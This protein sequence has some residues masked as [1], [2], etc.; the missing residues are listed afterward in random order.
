M[1][2]E[3]IESRLQRIEDERA[4]EKLVNTYA[5]RADAFDWAGWSETFTEDAIFD[6]AGMF[7][8]MKGRQ[9][10]H[11]LFKGDMDDLYENMQHVIVNL[12]F[13][14]AGDCASGTGNLIFA[15]TMDKDQLTRCHMAGGRFTWDFVR[16]KG[17]WRFSHTRLEV[18]WV[19]TT[20]TRQR[21]SP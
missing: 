14:V 8:L 19:K 9:I 12:D 4:I 21:K 18:L 3:T 10:I 16:T 20:P 17:G 13:D 1:S 11:D 7:K 15:G 5:K 2:L 6:T